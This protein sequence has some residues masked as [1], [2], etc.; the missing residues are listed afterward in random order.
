MNG[1]TK[2]VKYGKYRVVVGVATV[3]DGI[4]RTTLAAKAIAEEQS[5]G[6]SNDMEYVLRRFAHTV[7]YPAMVASVKEQSGFDT[8]PIPFDEFCQL[9]D[10]FV[11]QWEAATYEL[12]PHWSPQPPATEAE[13]EEKKRKARKST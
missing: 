10:D 7:V 8:W 5:A 1:E 12:N 13:V 3:L 11:L 4:R 2:V 6:E 9:P